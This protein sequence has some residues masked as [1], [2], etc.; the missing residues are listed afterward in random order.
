[1]G[2]DLLAETW[3]RRSL[4]TERWH[5]R[6]SEGLLPDRRVRGNAMQRLMKVAHCRGRRGGR[7]AEMR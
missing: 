4:P 1:M 3:A 2:V 7:C 6:R 5:A